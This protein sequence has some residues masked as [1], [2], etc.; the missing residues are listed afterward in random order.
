MFSAIIYLIFLGAILD[1]TQRS[2]SQ[3]DFSKARNKAL[4]NE[5]QHFLNPEETQLLSL[6][7]VKKMLK[8]TGEVYQGMRTVPVDLIVGSE[9]RYHDFDNH[10]FPKNNHLQQRWENIDRAHLENVILPP[11]N[12]YELGGLYFVRDGNHRVSVAKAQGIAD[13]D[14][15]VVS[16]QSEIKLKPGSTPTQMIR[17]V[18]QYEK[19][20]FYG[21]THFGDITDDWNLDFT[22]TGQYDV[23]FHHLLIHKYY[24]NQNIEE[25]IS[26]PDA[27]VSWYTNVYLP[28]I[29]VIK[30]QK[31]IR[32]FKG[33]TP[34][35]MYVWLIK[36]WDELKQRFGNDYSLQVA[37][38]SFTKEYGTGFFKRILRKFRSFL[39][40]I[41]S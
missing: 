20:V 5:L 28:V 17:Q 32:K 35:D 2:Q 1:M 23:I 6:E 26:M 7:D 24:I 11:I 19:R 37:A 13:L 9:G 18:I 8:P 4:F 27:I 21:E 38:Q 12:L 29:Q 34:A 22:A 39:K 41:F 40:K 14:A 30:Q 15:E 31:I 33:R 3:E 36:Y 16:L 25:E 10:F